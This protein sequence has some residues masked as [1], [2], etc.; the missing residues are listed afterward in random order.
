MPRKGRRVF[1]GLMP[2]DVCATCGQYIFVDEADLSLWEE[3]GVW[4]CA[5]VRW[6]SEGME[7]ARDL[8]RWRRGL[9]RARALGRPVPDLTE[10]F[11]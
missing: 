8:R 6:C 4:T 10:V 2:Y 5:N 7:M 11:G 9:D 1:G 3:E